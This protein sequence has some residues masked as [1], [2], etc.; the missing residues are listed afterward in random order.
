MCTLPEQNV[1]PKEEGC[2][3]E[4]EEFFASDCEEH[5]VRRLPQCR[6]TFRTYSSAVRNHIAAKVDSNLRCL[7]TSHNKCGLFHVYVTVSCRI[8]MESG[9]DGMTTPKARSSHLF[10]VACASRSQSARSAAIDLHGSE[11]ALP[12]PAE[13]IR[14]ASAA[15]S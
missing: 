5:H 15:T 9:Y 2:Q 4:R 1:I 11:G 8:V 12:K 14:L 13:A 3:A 6:K 10:L 7:L